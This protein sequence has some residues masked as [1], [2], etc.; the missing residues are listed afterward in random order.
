[1][2]ALSI[3][4]LLDKKP[5]TIIILTVLVLLIFIISRGQDRNWDLL[6]YHFYNGYALLNWR[7]SV[8]NIAAYWQTFFNPVINAISYLIIRYIAFPFST[9]IISLIQLSVIYPLYMI[10]KNLNYEFFKE[11]SNKLSLLILFLSILSPV[12]LSELGTTFY[13]SW[14]AVPIIFAI[15]IHLSQ[16]YKNIK[17]SKVFLSGFLLGMSFGF[18]LTNGLYLP[19]FFLFL[20]FSLYADQKKILSSIILFFISTFIGFLI[21][22]GWW[23]LYLYYE[24]QN[25]LMPFYN[26][27]FKSPYYALNNF[28]DL[29]W[30]FSSLGDFFLFF[31]D[32]A[33]G[34]KKTLEISFTDIRYLL[35]YIFSG[36]FFIRYLY[37]LQILTLKNF[38]TKTNSFIIFYLATIFLWGLMFAY[39]RYIIAL[40]LITGIFLSVLIYKC[41]FDKSKIIL[42]LSILIVM[43]FTFIRIPDWS[44]SKIRFSDVYDFNIKFPESI[45]SEPAKYLL[46]GAPFGYLLP[47][48]P[49]ESRFY[50]LWGKELSKVSYMKL[51]NDPSDLPIRVLTKYSLSAGMKERLTDL[52][53]PLKGLY[54]DCKYF[55]ALDFYITCELSKNNQEI[56]QVKY[57]LFF[58][59][60]NFK[61][62]SGLMSDSGFAWFTEQ[63]RLL[64]NNKASI[65]LSN[66]IPPGLYDIRIQGKKNLNTSNILTIRIGEHSITN[67]PTIGNFTIQNNIKINNSLENIIDFTLDNE[68][69]IFIQSIKLEKIS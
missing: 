45:K 64:Q 24:W 29:N 49:Q 56:T 37:S 62:S 8:D 53:M 2:S 55:N 23:S 12:W 50:G 68:D 20:L 41:K 28:R 16:D 63:G 47:Y 54:F 25:P 52:G 3:S 60:N 35:V 4:K 10:I 21:S 11:N 22:S 33:T 65:T 19:P 14:T 61:N 48:M 39:H 27:F 17:L 67:K 18:K 1:M 59:D 58:T 42:I 5:F 44:H 57:D 46:Y 69:E 36:T 26:A 13:S 31:F 9:V 6:N 38:C 15:A 43:C 32:A 34:T 30:K 66:N 51:L 40:E 7:Y